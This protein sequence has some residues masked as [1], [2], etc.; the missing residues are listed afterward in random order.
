[1]LSLSRGGA[2][3]LAPHTS[4]S[5]QPLHPQ[6]FPVVNNSIRQTYKGESE[7]FTFQLSRGGTAPLAPFRVPG[8]AY[9]KSAAALQ[10]SPDLS[11][12]PGRLLA[13]FVVFLPA[14]AR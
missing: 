6:L 10:L 7:A 3:P 1:M 13:G 11:I 4:H 5:L 12:C 8:P 2:A 14:N 9:S